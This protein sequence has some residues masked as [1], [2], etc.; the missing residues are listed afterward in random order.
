MLICQEHFALCLSSITAQFQEV[1]ARAHALEEEKQL[2]Q[3]KQ[4]QL[5]SATSVGGSKRF[6]EQNKTPSRL[7]STFQAKPKAAKWNSHTNKK[8]THNFHL[9]KMA[10]ASAKNLEVYLVLCM[11]VV[12][13][14]I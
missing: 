3:E 4:S 9:Q 13:M 2:K 10:E 8:E 7:N 6:G 12:Y 1:S 11:L 14:L 5:S